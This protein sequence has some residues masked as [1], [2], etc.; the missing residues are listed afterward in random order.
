MDKYLD[1]SNNSNSGL[2]NVGNL[3]RH[4]YDYSKEKSYQAELK[5]FKQKLSNKIH[6]F[7]PQ[8]MTDSFDNTI[9]LL[10]FQHLV[11]KKHPK[12]YVAIYNDLNISYENHDFE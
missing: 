10:W 2:D 11:S 4:T 5:V 8:K 12:D 7:N 9:N 3:S 1:N 6:K